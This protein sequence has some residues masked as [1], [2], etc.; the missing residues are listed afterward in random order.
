MSTQLI[1]PSCETA[2]SALIEGAEKPTLLRFAEFF[3]VHISNANTRAAYARATKNFLAWCEQRG[4]GEITGIQPLHVAGYREVLRQEGYSVPTVKQH[5]AAVRKL[6]D[7]LVTGHI[8]PVNLASSVRGPQYSVSRG[9][10]PVLSADQVSEL[11]QS[12]DT[13]DP[14]VSAAAPSWR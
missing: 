2:L 8:L 12:I 5:L 9:A 10:T 4:V 14:V 11:L 7:R 13:A 3:T 6:F 1:V